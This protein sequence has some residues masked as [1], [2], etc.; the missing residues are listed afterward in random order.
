MDRKKPDRESGF[1]DIRIKVR[2]KA[3]ILSKSGSWAVAL[4]ISWRRRI[5]K[6]LNLKNQNDQVMIIEWS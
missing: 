3:E 1:A 2:R 5:L 6:R 4:K